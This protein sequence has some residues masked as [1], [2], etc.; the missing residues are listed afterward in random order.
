MLT[1]HVLDLLLDSSQMLMAVCIFLFCLFLLTS[2]LTAFLITIVFILKL[3][4]VSK[5]HLQ[6]L[7]PK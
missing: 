4:I 5:G 6:Q 7:T 1:A 3:L 2:L